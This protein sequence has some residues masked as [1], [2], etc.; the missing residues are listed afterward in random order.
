MQFDQYTDRDTGFMEKVANEIVVSK[1]E[2]LKDK[3]YAL[4]IKTAN[5][6]VRQFPICDKET[7]IVS[8]IYLQKNASVMHPEYVK[9]AGARIREAFER[10]GAGIPRVF[11]D[12]P[13]G[14][15]E[16]E[17]DHKPFEKQAHVPYGLPDEKKFPM[18]DK[19]HL[20]KAIEFAKYAEQNLTQEQKHELNKN[21]NKRAKDLKVN[22]APKENTKLNTK[23]ASDMKFFVR[24]LEDEV[25]EKYLKL[26]EIASEGKLT[27]KQACEAVHA[28]NK[29]YGLDN[30]KYRMTPE[31]LILDSGTMEVPH[32]VKTASAISEA[33]QGPFSKRFQKALIEHFDPEMVRD[34]AQQP[35]VIFD[36]LPV[37]VQETIMMLLKQAEGDGDSEPRRNSEEAR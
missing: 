28:M 16:F 7:T 26:A 19:E 12:F 20:F 13:V 30:Y 29:V 3:D 25:A 5:K 32:R 8:A 4:I 11:A 10:F 9:I 31:R 22:L 27:T 24:N 14:C 6:R 34:L 36:S 23:L 21:I 35:D 18:P 2:D 37:P 17:T 15:D 33:F 1:R